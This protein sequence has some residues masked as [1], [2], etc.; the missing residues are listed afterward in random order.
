MYDRDE[1]G[2]EHE[3]QASLQWPATVVLC[4]FMLCVT[5]LI[6]VWIIW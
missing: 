2:H 5:E 4:T 1:H 6:A 3:E